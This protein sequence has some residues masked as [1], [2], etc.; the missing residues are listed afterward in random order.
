[1]RIE[2]RTLAGDAGDRPGQNGAPA[3]AAGDV[4]AHSVPAL[5]RCIKQDAERGSVLLEE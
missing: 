2:N 4:T 3:E 1:M 5:L